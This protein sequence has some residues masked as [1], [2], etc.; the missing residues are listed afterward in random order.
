MTGPRYLSLY[1]QLKEWPD[2]EDLGRSPLSAQRKK[3]PEGT[4]P[5]PFLLGLP[6]G[7]SPLNNL[8][9]Q[10]LFLPC[11]FDTRIFQIRLSLLWGNESNS[12]IPSIR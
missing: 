3:A 12:S 6:S 2:G 10:G 5:N 4:T 1:M 7:H 9:T 11:K 8:E